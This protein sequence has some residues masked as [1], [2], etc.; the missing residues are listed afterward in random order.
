[1]CV[2]TPECASSADPSLHLSPSSWALGCHLLATALAALSVSLS[3]V[4]A[5]WTGAALVAILILGGWGWLSWR[6]QPKLRFFLSGEQVL[7]LA[8][9][10]CEPARQVTVR[11]TWHLSVWLLQLQYREPG[12][13]RWHSILV[14][15]DSASEETRR[16]LRSHEGFAAVRTGSES[17]KV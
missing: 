15:P 3:A 6:R 16:I 8:E 10:A 7:L 9:N 17:K 5:V 2:P 13:H 11:R 1:M 12:Q 14:W 4:P